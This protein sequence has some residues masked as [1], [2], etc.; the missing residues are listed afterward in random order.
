MLDKNCFFSSGAP[1][2]R[3]SGTRD[4]GPRWAAGLQRVQG[5]SHT[6]EPRVR[7][8]PPVG[9][10]APAACQSSLYPLPPVG[11]GL[12][13]CVR[14]VLVPPAPGWQG[15]S[16]SVPDQR[17]RPRP[18]DTFLESTYPEMQSKHI[19]RVNDS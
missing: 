11:G 10:G 6:P 15:G 12:W 2:A 14:A 8:Q 7:Q 9:K 16:S 17:A 3:Q 13:P 19:P 1:A 5:S 4:P 18:P